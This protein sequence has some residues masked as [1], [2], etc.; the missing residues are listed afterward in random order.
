MNEIPRASF[1][2]S[3]SPPS[4]LQQSNSFRLY[5]RKHSSINHQAD[6]GEA[7]KAELAERESRRNSKRQE[8]VRFD[9]LLTVRSGMSNEIYYGHDSRKCFGCSMDKFV[10]GGNF[11][12]IVMVIDC[13]AQE[14]RVLIPAAT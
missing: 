10:I 7:D 1:A 2:L 4:P 14:W 11:T 12:F 8:L 5:R 13:A 9:L 3:L 6:E